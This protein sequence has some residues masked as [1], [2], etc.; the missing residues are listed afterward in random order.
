MRTGMVVI[1]HELSGQ[2]PQVSLALADNMI[3][4][5]A[6]DTAQWTLA[7]GIGLGNLNGYVQ[8]A[9]ASSFGPS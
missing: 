2:P 4:A 5:L 7:D 8:Q 1:I 3:E 9:N 6:A